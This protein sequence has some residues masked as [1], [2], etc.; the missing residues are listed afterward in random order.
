MLPRL[1]RHLHCDEYKDD[2]QD[3]R[4]CGCHANP[5]LPSVK[6]V[7][8]RG[9]RGRRRPH[10]RLVF[11]RA[12][13]IGVCRAMISVVP[14]TRQEVSM[15]CCGKS[16]G[17]EDRRIFV[18]LRRARYEVILPRLSRPTICRARQV[19]AIHASRFEG[20]QDGRILETIVVQPCARLSRVAIIRRD[21]ARPVYCD[22][23]RK[24]AHNL[25]NGKDTRDNGPK[26]RTCNGIRFASSKSLREPVLGDHDHIKLL[27]E[28]SGLFFGG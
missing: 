24:Q 9:S 20:T 21:A 8:K 28:S 10:E 14:C 11:S 2:I 26:A 3:H 27:H 4:I 15:L 22:P 19:V 1:G 5:C 6:A 7:G 16:F 23:E 12:P 25:C 18:M 17:A 13:Y